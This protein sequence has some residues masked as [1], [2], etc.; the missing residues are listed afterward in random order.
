MNFQQI[1]EMVSWKHRLPS[2]RVLSNIRTAPEVRARH[3]IMFIAYNNSYSVP[4]ITK[5][6]KRD[7]TSV[8]NGIKRHKERMK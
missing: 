5:L 4:Q 1:V 8:L 6:I 3:E 2:D 7:Y